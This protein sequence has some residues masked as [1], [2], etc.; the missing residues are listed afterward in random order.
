MTRPN[1]PRLIEIN[2]RKLP[3]PPDACI[4]VYF[5]EA[6]ANPESEEAT[7]C[8]LFNSLEG[9]WAFLGE[10]LFEGGKGHVLAYDIV[11]PTKPKM[12]RDM[13]SI[14]IPAKKE[15]PE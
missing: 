15:K 11:W 13:G 12:L 7:H 4:L 3:L 10:S 5:A 8:H 2:G 6:F 9:A 14:E 1:P